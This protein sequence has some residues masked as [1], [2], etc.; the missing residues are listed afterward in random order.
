MKNYPVIFELQH[1]FNTIVKKTV[2]KFLVSKKIL[3]CNQTMKTIK[4]ILIW[5]YEEK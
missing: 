1:V 4:R 2:Q 3:K 5:R